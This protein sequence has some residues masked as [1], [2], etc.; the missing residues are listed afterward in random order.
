[1]S[2]PPLPA[3]RQRLIR[4]ALLR[5]GSITVAEVSRTLGVTETTVRRDI[6]QL[7]E[8][9]VLV[10]VHGGATALVNQPTTR[11]GSLPTSATMVVPTDDFHWGAIV[12]AVRAAAR[13]AELPLHVHRDDTLTPELLHRLADDAPHGWLL[14]PPLAAPARDAF[15]DWLDRCPTPVVLLEREASP[16]V[17]LGV[18]SVASDHARNAA[19]VVRHLN[20]LG[21]ERIGMMVPAGGA[22]ADEYVR[23]WQQALIRRGLPVTPVLPSIDIIDPGRAELTD[24]VVE[25]LRTDRHTAVLVLGDPHAMVLLQICQEVGIAVPGDLS[26]VS[27]GDYMASWGHPALNALRPPYETLGATAVRLLLARMR[28]GSPAP[29]QH[30]RLEG[31]LV[32]RETVAPPPS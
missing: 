3:Q 4:E 27:F 21:H 19:A 2:R 9:G 26:V 20:R 15:D 24:R 13:A 32:A 23:G 1:M 28:G 18:Q 5:D 10:R 14:A 22:R 7:A 31:T 25:A 11:H 8:Q 16:G 17:G 29:G 6:N 30:V 12:A